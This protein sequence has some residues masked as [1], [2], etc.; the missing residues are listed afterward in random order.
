[1]NDKRLVE[2][3]TTIPRPCLEASTS[4]LNVD[5]L[6]FEF[7]IDTQLSLINLLNGLVILFKTQMEILKGD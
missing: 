3:A 7:T 4:A 1:M 2:L 5:T 6:R